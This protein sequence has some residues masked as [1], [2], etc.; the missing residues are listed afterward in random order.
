[1]ALGRINFI[2]KP[3]RS[4]ENRLRP[5][6][7]GERRSPFAFCFNEEVVP[8]RSPFAFRV[9]VFFKTLMMRSTHPTIMAMQARLGRVCH[10]T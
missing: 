2:N 3:S 7:F 9:F 1:M 10:E 6:F 5:F 4:L 8:S